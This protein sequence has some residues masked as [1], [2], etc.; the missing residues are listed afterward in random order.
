M[1]TLRYGNTNTYYVPGAAGGLLID[2]DLAGSLPRFFKAVKAAGISVDEIAYVMAT[3]YHPDHM[4]II[5]QLQKLGVRL[6][7][8]DVQKNGIRF[9]DRIFARDRSLQESDY[10][11]VDED[12]AVVISC[13]E[14]RRLLE[15]IGI[16]GEIVSTPSHSEDSVSVILDDGSCFVGDLEPAGYIEAYGGNPALERDWELVLGTGAKQKAKHIYYAHVNDKEI[17]TNADT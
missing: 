1:K 9:S 16:A 5:G 4:G 7:L 6:L 3:H 13:A 17:D 8:I 15:S 14:S 12:A 11:P 10:V 2:T